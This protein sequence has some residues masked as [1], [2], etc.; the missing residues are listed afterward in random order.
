MTTY[1]FPI[2]HGYFSPVHGK[3]HGFFW[4]PSLPAGY[5]CVGVDMEWK[6]NWMGMPTGGIV[7][8]GYHELPL[9]APSV[10]NY[11]DNRIHRN[12]LQVQF[13]RGQTKMVHLTDFENVVNRNHSGGF[14]VVAGIDST[15]MNYYGYGTPARFVYSWSKVEGS[16][17]R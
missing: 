16:W 17:T 15:S 6:A 4:C 8:F 11:S 7:P 13:N 3:Q 2:Y 10:V 14:G 5:I 9:P 12:L 1:A